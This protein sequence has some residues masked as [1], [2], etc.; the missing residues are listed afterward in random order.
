MYEKVVL[1]D[2]SVVWIKTGPR[3][4]RHE[5]A[6]MEFARWEASEIRKKISAHRASRSQGIEL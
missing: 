2:G 5:I 6:R 4:S 3:I 1:R